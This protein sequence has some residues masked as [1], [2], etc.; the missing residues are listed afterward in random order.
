MAGKQLH[1][2]ITRGR[3][4]HDTVHVTFEERFLPQFLWLW[5][6]T[7]FDCY[8]FSSIFWGIMVLSRK[9]P[10]LFRREEEE[11]QEGEEAGEKSKV[12]VVEAAEVKNKHFWDFL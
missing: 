7:C 9:V 1:K 11:E 4:V 10:N 12:D 8:F 3:C 6:S 5:G 2:S